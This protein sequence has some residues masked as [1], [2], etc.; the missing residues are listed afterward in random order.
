MPKNPFLKTIFKDVET[1]KN[2]SVFERPEVEYIL[3]GL[4]SFSTKKSVT[5][6]A[7][8]VK[9]GVTRIFCKQSALFRRYDPFDRVPNTAL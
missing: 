8:P 4:Y 7:N 5:G 1:K 2:T 9:S 3:R 6:F